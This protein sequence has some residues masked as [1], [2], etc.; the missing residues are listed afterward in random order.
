MRTSLW[1]VAI[2]TG[3]IL[4]GCDSSEQ[5]KA[6]KAPAAQPSVKAEKVTAV[7]KAKVVAPVDETAQ[8]FSEQVEVQEE[9]A[10]KMTE[11][12]ME[13]AGKS[14]STAINDSIKVADDTVAE[15]EKQAIAKVAVVKSATVEPVAA[16]K[17]ATV[18]QEIVLEASKGNV[19]FP[20]GMHADAY[21]CSI[22]HGD[23]TPAAFDLT[24]D[25]AH[26]VCKS[27]HKDEGAGPT[28]CSGCH[29]K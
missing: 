15:G 16:A 2:T 14:A 25:V 26:K 21:E 20:H 9:Q 5:P 27:C 22:C 6:Q 24:K 3:L 12:A 4:F 10:V 19:T 23:G 17:K 13:D 28:G 7:E 29:K 18:P 1:I 11:T 8:V